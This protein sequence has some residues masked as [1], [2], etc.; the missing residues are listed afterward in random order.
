MRRNEDG[1]Y[2]RFG[3]K[4]GG[5]GAA[6]FDKALDERRK[7]AGGTKAG[8]DWFGTYA[9][10]KAAGTI[11]PCRLHGS[12]SNARRAASAQIAKI[13]LDLAAYIARCFR[14]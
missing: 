8:G 1:E 5:S 9:A 6:W 7:A 10:E 12:R 13:P 3:V 14:P 2:T 11:S 4:Q